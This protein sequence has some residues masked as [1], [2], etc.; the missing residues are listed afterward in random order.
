M[1]ELIRSGLLAASA[2]IAIIQSGLIFST[3]PFIISP[4]S[5]PVNP[6]T[7]GVRLLK[8]LTDSSIASG[9]CSL[10]CLVTSTFPDTSGPNISGVA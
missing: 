6:I 7:P 3:T 1:V 2:S 9:A 4:V 8:V 10:R 5:I